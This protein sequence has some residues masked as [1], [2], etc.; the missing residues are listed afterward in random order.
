MKKQFMFRLIAVAIMFLAFFS[1]AKAQ[2]T[3]TLNYATNN[4]SLGFYCSA[5]TEVYFYIEATSTGMLATDSLELFINFGDGNS[6]HTKYA[7]IGGGYFWIYE[8]HYY[9]TP[10]N[11][12]C[13][14]IVRV[15]NGASDTIT[16]MNE[17]IVSNGCGEVSGRAYLDANANC[18]YDVGESLV[19]GLMMSIYNG[20]GTTRYPITD[21]DGKYSWNVP[22]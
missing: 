18:T 9:L 12:N 21:F 2:M 11:F 10:G 13:Q 1:G 19:P 14:Y 22:Y 20:I 15:P 4:D 16:N 5:P 7:N 8:T 6:L 3:V 17:V